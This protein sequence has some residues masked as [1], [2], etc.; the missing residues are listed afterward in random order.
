MQL[1]PNARADDSHLRFVLGDRVVSFSLAA[2]TTFGEVARTL[3]EYS[4]E[5]HGDPSSIVVTVARTML[6]S[7]R[8]AAQAGRTRTA[9]GCSQS[10]PGSLKN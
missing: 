10:A 7:P 3:G 9:G 8:Q 6:K 4:D 5:H 2:D 1:S